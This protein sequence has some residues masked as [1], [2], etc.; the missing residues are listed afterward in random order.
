MTRHQIAVWACVRRV[1]IFRNVVIANHEGLMPSSVNCLTHILPRVQEQSV[2]I[3]IHHGMRQ[4]TKKTESF[5]NDCIPIP[6]AKVPRT[7][8]KGSVL[9]VDIEMIAACQDPK[10]EYGTAK[11][12]NR[13]NSHLISTRNRLRGGNWDGRTIS[14]H[15]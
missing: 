4:G 14:W 7:T 3:P 6:T 11:S 1:I 13:T 2:L 15:F 10:A 9:I 5:L 8:R 12:T